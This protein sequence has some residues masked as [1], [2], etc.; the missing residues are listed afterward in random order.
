MIKSHTCYQSIHFLPLVQLQ[1]SKQR[2]PDLIPS[3]QLLSLKLQ[4]RDVI[5]VLVLLQAE[6]IQTG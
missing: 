4:L 2:S 3:G 6:D 1:L 5:L